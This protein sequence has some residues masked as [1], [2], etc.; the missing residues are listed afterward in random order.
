MYYLAESF[1]VIIL[2]DVDEFF[3]SLTIVFSH[4]DLSSSE[5][6]KHKLFHNFLHFI[7]VVF[8]EIQEVKVSRK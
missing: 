4:F 1:L 7:S 5:Y 8:L 3:S 6:I 2:K